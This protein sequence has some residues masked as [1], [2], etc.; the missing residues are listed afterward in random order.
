MEEPPDP[1]GSQPLFTPMDTITNEERPRKRHA[2]DSDS[3]QA[4]KSISNPE[5]ASASYELVYTHPDLDESAR[6]YS[7]NDL[8]P[9]IVHI[10]RNNT[11]PSA[12]LSVRAIKIGL[13]LHQSNVQNI[14]RDGIKNIGSRRVS[15]QFKTAE[16]ANK[17]ISHSCLATHKYT[18]TIPSYHV[19]RIGIVRGV[20]VD[21]D[22]SRL[23]EAMDTDGCGKVLKA[24]RLS[25]KKTVNDTTVW[26]PTQSVVVTFEGQRLP[27]HVYVFH[28]SL[29]VETYM[30]P[31][32]Q[33]F[34]CCRFGHVKTQ[35]RSDPRC[36]KC[37][38]DHPGESCLVP[39]SS[40]TCL[41]CM[42]CHYATDKDCFEQGR[43]RTIKNIMSEKS[44][45]YREAELQAPLQLRRSFANVLSSNIPHSNTPFNIPP[46][47]TNYSQSQPQKLS[48]RKTVFTTP[49]P[50]PNLSKGY[51]QRAHLNIVGDVHSSMPNGHA[52]GNDT[53]SPPENLVDLILA[54][55]KNI[56]SKFSDNIP[57]NVA[58]QIF[59]ISQLITNT[60]GSSSLRTM[61]QSQS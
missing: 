48:Y 61:E 31:T 32:I 28:T 21:W 29:L 54:L 39:K 15:V 40:A 36:Y 43:Q 5:A 41:F 56:I 14:V 49:R 30:L 11:D 53:I 60:N 57:N 37:S 8:G 16:D 7:D 18:A 26:E 46:S 27:N 10:A 9:F 55:L 33:C 13:L 45:S 3:S 44:I 34:K 42:G 25:R 22:V 4:K 52:L 1:G 17:F 59:E 35:C 24:R 19:S 23:A 51:D 2:S 47:D 12:N 58:S 38:E 50:R 20:P 6:K